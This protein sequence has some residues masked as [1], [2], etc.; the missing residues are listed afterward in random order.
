MRWRAAARRLSLLVTLLVVALPGTLDARPDG[1]LRLA[2]RERVWLGS[3]MS[4]GIDMSYV[5]TA[6]PHFAGEQGAFTGAP[7]RGG[8]LAL[9]WIP[10]GEAVFG[11]LGFGIAASYLTSD[12]RNVDGASRQLVVLPTEAYA[13]YRADFFHQQLFVPFA[14][15]GTSFTFYKNPGRVWYVYPGLD[16]SVG[17]EICLS[18]LEPRVARQ[19]DATWGIND[20]YLLVE[21]VRSEFLAG[22]R[23]PDF[24]HE[25]IRLGLR[26][27]M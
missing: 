23:G 9:E 20:T 21:V 19:M 10:F 2:R 7:M 27:E 1:E 25:A 14:K 3:P 5:A 18:H 22:Y 17:L 11:K 26:F 13:A 6:F 24:R 16:T 8:R 4:T 12:P 15:I